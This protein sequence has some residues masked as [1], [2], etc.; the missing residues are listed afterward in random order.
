MVEIFTLSTKRVEI[1][2]RMF[3]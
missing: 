2:T 1:A 3:H